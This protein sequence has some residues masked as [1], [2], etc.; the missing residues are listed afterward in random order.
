MKKQFLNR[1]SNNKI[2]L[3]KVSLTKF[4]FF[5]YYVF[6]DEKKKYTWHEKLSQGE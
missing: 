3:T 5:K 2:K 6:T 4:M 1:N